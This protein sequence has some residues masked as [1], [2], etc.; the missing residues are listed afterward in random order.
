MRYPSPRTSCGAKARL[1][2][3]RWLGFIGLAAESALQYCR[4]FLEGMG[5]A[6]NRPPMGIQ[7][8]TRTVVHWFDPSGDDFKLLTTGATDARN[9]STLAR[10]I[11]FCLRHTSTVP[12][13]VLV[14]PLTLRRG[15]GWKGLAAN[16]TLSRKPE[17]VA[18][19]SAK[20]STVGTCTATKLSGLPTWFEDS[21]TSLAGSR[22]QLRLELGIP[23][24]SIRA[25][26]C[27]P[28]V[29][30]E[31]FAAL[32][33]DVIVRHLRTLLVGLAWCFWRGLRHQGP[34][35]SVA[36]QATLALP[37]YSTLGAVA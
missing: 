32:G 25:V 22:S 24:A 20:T 11:E 14:L 29:V 37:D 16:L 13:T 15:G 19:L 27:L 26:F 17:F 23:E 12:G 36:D 5:I 8:I 21:S 6:T 33:A 2:G 7:A 9:P 34:Q 1:L 28:F 4:W 10:R 30:G 35:S 18:R 31:G 3:K